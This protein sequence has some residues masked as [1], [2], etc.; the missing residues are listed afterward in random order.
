MSQD[1]FNQGE[2]QSVEIKKAEDRQGKVESEVEY[3]PLISW[4]KAR[5]IVA[6]LG[7]A[8]LVGVA[9]SIVG[10]TLHRVIDQNL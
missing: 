9:A 2:S 7:V 1:S 4:S 10:T 5:K 8:M 6:V 3:D